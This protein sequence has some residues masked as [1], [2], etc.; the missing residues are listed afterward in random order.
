M[1]ITL[2]NTDTRESPYIGHTTPISGHVAQYARHEMQNN[3]MILVTKPFGWITNDLPTFVITDPSHYK[4]RSLVTNIFKTK[5]Q[6]YRNSYLF[7]TQIFE[8][9]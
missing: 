1:T 8:Y 2:P 6:P 9:Q 7:I 5:R 3:F 4:K